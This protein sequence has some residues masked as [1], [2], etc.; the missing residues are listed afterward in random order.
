M[1]KI[2]FFTSLSCVVL[3]FNF[4]TVKE[5]NRHGRV[6]DG[7]SGILGSVRH[8]VNSARWRTLNISL[9]LTLGKL[10]IHAVAMLKKKKPNQKL[11]F[12]N[13]TEN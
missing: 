2:I 3:F 1:N 6:G 13:K 4:L 10:S 11:S 9:R 7:E 8:Q 12:I 5:V